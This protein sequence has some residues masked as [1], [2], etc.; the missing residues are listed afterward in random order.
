MPFLSSLDNLLQDK[1]IVSQKSV[2]NNKTCSISVCGA[3]PLNHM[4]IRV[5]C[6]QF[7]THVEVRHVWHRVTLRSNF[8]FK[9]AQ[10]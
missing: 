4:E 10:S 7:K 8:I 2:E 5:I 3:T 1:H 6:F 9:V